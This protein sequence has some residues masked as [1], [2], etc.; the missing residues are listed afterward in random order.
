MSSPTVNARRARVRRIRLRVAAGAASAFVALWGAVWAFGQPG[1]ATA[2]AASPTTQAPA[3]Q[4][5]GA[6]PSQGSASGPSPVIT[7]QS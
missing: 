7:G 2:N 6:D 3:V 1:G 4:D 5:P